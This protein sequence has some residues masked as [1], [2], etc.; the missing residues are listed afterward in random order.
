MICD[1][2]II[3]ENADLTDINLSNAELNEVY[4]MGA[5][6]TG[7]N[8]SNAS[9]YIVSLASANLEQAIFPGLFH[10]KQLLQNV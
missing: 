3:L 1:R 5:N 4:L 9:L 8:L 10:S 2:Y 7:A 6:L